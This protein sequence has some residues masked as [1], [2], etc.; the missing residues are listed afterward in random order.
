MLPPCRWCGTETASE[1]NWGAWA[2][3]CSIGCKEIFIK[4]S[5]EHDLTESHEECKWHEAWA[6]Q[7][8]RF[9][10]LIQQS[11]ELVDMQDLTIRVLDDFPDAR[12]ALDEAVIQMEQRIKE[13]QL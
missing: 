7:S 4:K 1:L 12:A 9:S 13:K 2:P 5:H 10:E 8:R 6:E 11:Q 3:F